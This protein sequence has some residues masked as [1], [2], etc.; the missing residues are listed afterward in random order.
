MFAL[1]KRVIHDCLTG[2]DGVTYDPARVYGG[3]AV[4]V[5]LANSMF[6]LYRNQPWGPVDFGTGF[7]LLM[8]GFGA[9]VA[10]KAKTEPGE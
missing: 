10:I 5:F 3:M 7:G 1:I 8:A 9:A 6:A 2:I 4:I